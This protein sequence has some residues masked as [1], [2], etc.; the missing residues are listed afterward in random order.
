MKEYIL[1]ILESFEYRINFK[2]YWKRRMTVQSCVWGGGYVRYIIY[3]G[4]EG[5]KQNLAQQPA[6]DCQQKKVYAAILMSLLLCLMVL[7]VL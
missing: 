7:A 6:L 4:S 1:N 5:R 2:K 3:Y